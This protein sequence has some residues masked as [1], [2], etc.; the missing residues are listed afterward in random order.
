MTEITQADRDAAASGYFAWCSGNPVIPD[1]MKAGNADD[2]SMVQAFARHR[3]EERAAIVAYFR[4]IAKCIRL[5]ADEGLWYPLTECDVQDAIDQY[6]RCAEWIEEGEH[7]QSQM[8]SNLIPK[9]DPLVDAMRDCGFM[10]IN[11]AVDE[12][13]AELAKRGLEIR[14]KE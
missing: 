7:L 12:L 11:A 4:H 9:P 3:M 14:E 2:H 1:R 8:P 13:R 10:D 6:D 5:D